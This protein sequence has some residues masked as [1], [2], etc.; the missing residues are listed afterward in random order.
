[1]SHFFNGKIPNIEGVAQRRNQ[2]AAAAEPPQNTHYCQQDQ[3]GNRNM[4]FC[5]EEPIKRL[6]VSLLI[7]RKRREEAWGTDKVSWM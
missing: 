7:H 1:M 6:L 2:V 4:R 5:L 3:M